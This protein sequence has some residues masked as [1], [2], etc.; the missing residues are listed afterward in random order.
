MPGTKILVLLFK[1]GALSEKKFWGGLDQP[2]ISGSL[3]F[4]SSLSIP[5]LPIF[6]HLA[7]VD[8]ATCCAVESQAG[9]TRQRGISSQ[10]TLLETRGKGKAHHVVNIPLTRNAGVTLRY[11]TVE[12]P[13][14]IPL[15]GVRDP[16]G[17]SS[18]T[19]A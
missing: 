14:R 3:V 8:V 12:N 5:S 11:Y 4:I 18:V 1:K 7:R 17:S 2:Q 19:P 13:L 9:R 10:C 16:Q 15:A 6:L